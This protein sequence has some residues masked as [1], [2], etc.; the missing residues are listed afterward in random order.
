M[1]VTLTHPGGHTSPSYTVSG[2]YNH[3]STRQNGHLVDLKTKE[4]YHSLKQ[5]QQQHNNK[6]NWKI[7]SGNLN[8]RRAGL[9]NHIKLTVR[10]KEQCATGRRWACGER[11]A[12]SALDIPN[13]EEP[14]VFRLSIIMLMKWRARQW[15]KGW[16]F[17]WH[18]HIFRFIPRLTLESRCT[19]GEC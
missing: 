11:Q 9:T 3:E 10:L 17:E 2:S 16:S 4:A 5:H 13:L 6:N 18:L 1:A 14:N 7:V 15:D 19:C 12:A 8:R